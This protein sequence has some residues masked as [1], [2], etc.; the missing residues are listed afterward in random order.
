MNVSNINK[1]GCMQTEKIF[2]SDLKAAIPP[3]FFLRKNGWLSAR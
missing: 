1:F 3:E 2:Y